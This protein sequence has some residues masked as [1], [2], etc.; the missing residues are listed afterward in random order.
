M[1]QGVTVN[2]R[3]R[4]R[5]VLIFVELKRKLNGTSVSEASI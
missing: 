4:K 3:Y 2:T 5:Q 1:E